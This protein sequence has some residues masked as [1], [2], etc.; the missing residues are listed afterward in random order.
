[1][2]VLKSVIFIKNFHY[3]SKHWVNYFET[4]VSFFKKY[5]NEGQNQCKVLF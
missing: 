3:E 2:C 5:E 1:M 4:R